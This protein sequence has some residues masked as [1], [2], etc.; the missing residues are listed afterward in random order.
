V[1]DDIV[2]ID[3]AEVEARMAAAMD[4]YRDQLMASLKKIYE[5]TEETLL[6]IMAAGVPASE[7]IYIGPK[8]KFWHNS[9][10]ITAY[11]GFHNE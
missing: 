1:A 4:P 7:I 3:M 10:Y 9:V 2:N 11:I 8:P 6:A 5:E